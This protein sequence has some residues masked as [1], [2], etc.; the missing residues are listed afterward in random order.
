MPNILSRWSRRQFVKATG[1]GSSLAG[2]FSVRHLL[3][4]ETGSKPVMA[5][6]ARK[7]IYQQLGI[8]P[9]INAAGTFTVLSASVMPREVVQAMEEASRHHVSIPELQH[10]VGKRISELL[11][12]EAA[13][14]TSGAAAAL[15]LGTAAC[16]AGKDPQKIQRFIQE[17]KK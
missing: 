8:R 13:L 10:A 12:S 15:T 7:S 1:L 17:I 3:G 6:I 4:A 2:L 11:G 16:V 14:V 9:L 5:A